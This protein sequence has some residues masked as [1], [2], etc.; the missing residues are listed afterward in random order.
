MPRTVYKPGGLTVFPPHAAPSGDC[1]LARLLAEEPWR[2]ALG[3]PEGF[4]GGIAHRL[5]VST[6]GAVWVADDPEELARMREAFG[7]GRLRKTY[8]FV[9]GKDVPWDANRCERPI[10]HARRRKNRMVV[11][12][13]PTTPH[14]GRWFPARSAFSRW[15]GPLWR[16]V[17][18]TGVTHQIRVHAAFLGL[19]LAGDRRYGGGPRPADAPEG[20]DFLL[21][22][23]GLEGDGWSTDPVAEPAWLTAR[24]SSSPRPRSAARRRR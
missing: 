24:S 2:A 7:T 21:H 14:R 6:S 23:I 20:V 10:A 15:S 12:R 4:A 1:V 22:H 3:W 13:G 11:Q 19:P 17:I 18:T 9:A 8:A 5:D 16:V